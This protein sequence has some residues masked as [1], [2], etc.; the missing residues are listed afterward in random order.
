MT[1]EDS[2]PNSDTESPKKEPLE[3]LYN[4]LLEAHEALKEDLEQGRSQRKALCERNERLKQAMK[5]VERES[6]DIR[7]TSSQIRNENAM[8]V[9]IAFNQDGSKEGLQAK[10]DEL[11]AKLKEAQVEGGQS[12]KRKAHIEKQDAEIHSL[13]KTVTDLQR[14]LRRRQERVDEEAK[15]AWSN[16]KESF[17]QRIGQKIEQL[18]HQ[19]IEISRLKAV[20]A[21]LKD[22]LEEG[23]EQ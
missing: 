10:V 1:T 23:K 20:N 17:K 19:A 12:K 7:N 5:K 16:E 3:T 14:Q 8:L 11:W 22:Q 9:E 2:T 18:D 15:N 4:T 6:L 13:W 21:N